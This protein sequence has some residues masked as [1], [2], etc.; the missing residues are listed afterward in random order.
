[1]A[2][3]LILFADCLGSGGANANARGDDEDLKSFAM[4][5]NQNR[6]KGNKINANDFVALCNIECN[7][8][9]VGCLKRVSFVMLKKKLFDLLNRIILSSITL[10]CCP[11]IE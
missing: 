9:L 4:D 8:F 2:V 3:T 6:E 5:K 10:T 7:N 1:M 11:S